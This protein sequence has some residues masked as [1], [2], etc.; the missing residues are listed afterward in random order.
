MKD[1]L[2][3]HHTSLKQIT[4][5]TPGD[6]LILLYEPKKLPR[7]WAT[8]PYLDPITIFLCWGLLPVPLPVGVDLLATQHESQPIFL[9]FYIIF[10]LCRLFYQ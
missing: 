10:W 6:P 9:I 5:A 1:L 7:P 3:C 8:P 4:P 2:L